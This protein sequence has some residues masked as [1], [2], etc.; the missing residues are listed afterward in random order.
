M[1]DFGKFTQGSGFAPGRKRILYLSIVFSVA[2]AIAVSCVSFL[3]LSGEQGARDSKVAGIMENLSSVSGEP[4]NILIL[5]VDKRPEGDSAVEGVRA[6]TIMLARVYPKSGDIKLVSIP[7]DLLVEVSPSE[8]NKINAAY[9]YGGASET[10]SAVE[11]FANVRVD[12]YAVMD[13]AGFEQVVDAM[14]GLKIDVDENQAPPYW[15]VKDGVQWLGGRKA[16][17]YARYRDTPGGDLD[18]I[19]RQQEIMAALR[20]K[21]FR[22]RSVERLPRIT[23][24][25]ARNVETDMSLTRMA[26]LGKAF[27]KHGRNSVM[28]ATQLEGT[29]DTLPNGSEVLVPNDVENE[30]ILRDFR[31]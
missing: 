8:E 11:H 18:R 25:V 5:G 20:S 19:R 3:L 27:S 13:F 15:K 31:D 22:W 2:L 17:I 16:L 23:R 30:L 9:A 24:A 6:D 12:H 29:P 26:S 4:Q 28:T 10:R 14:G 21:A 1:H 7:R